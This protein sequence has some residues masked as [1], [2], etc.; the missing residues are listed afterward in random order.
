M[1]ETALY[2]AVEMEN[3]SQV[4]L[5]LDYN[6]DPNIAQNDGFIPLHAAVMK[7]NIEIVEVLL[8]FKSN[9]NHKS[10]VY[11]QT[12]VHHA[13]KYNIKTAILMLLV[14]F[15]GSLTIRDSNNKRPIDYVNSDE[16][17]EIISIMRQRNEEAFVTPQKE[18][19]ISYNGKFTPNKDNH[20]IL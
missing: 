7:Q 20:F 12:P 1:G 18:E 16:M 19:T 17:R 15:K 3:I 11:S 2:Q 6:A 9:P 4:K 8:Q 10:K 13:I 14:Q 5:L